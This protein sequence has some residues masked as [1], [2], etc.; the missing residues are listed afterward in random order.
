M[1]GRTP[2]GREEIAG[3]VDQISVNR[4]QSLTGIWLSS[5]ALVAPSGQ[6]VAACFPLMVRAGGFMVITVDQP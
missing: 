1:S 6:C 3:F 4:P 5:D 2:L